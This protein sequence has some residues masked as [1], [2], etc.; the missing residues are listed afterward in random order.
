M[1]VSTPDSRGDRTSRPMAGY[2]GVENE[3]CEFQCRLIRLRVMSE[4]QFHRRV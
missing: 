3:P 1:D 2:K 4:L